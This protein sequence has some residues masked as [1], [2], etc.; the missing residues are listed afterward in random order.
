M[1]SCTYDHVPHFI[2]LVQTFLVAL[3]ISRYFDCS[4]LNLWFSGIDVRDEAPLI[5]SQLDEATT[6]LVLDSTPNVLSIGRR[7]IDNGYGFVWYPYSHH[8][9]LVPPRGRRALSC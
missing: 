8:P 7:C 5:I 9:V 2:V 3:E 6:A 4:F 1:N